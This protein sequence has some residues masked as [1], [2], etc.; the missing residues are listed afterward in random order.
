MPVSIAAP[1][2]MSSRDATTGAPRRPVAR[3]ESASISMSSTIAW[4][5][6]ARTLP[7]SSYRAVPPGSSAAAATAAIPP[8]RP[9]RRAMPASSIASAAQRFVAKNAAALTESGVSAVSAAMRTTAASREIS[10]SSTAIACRRCVVG[11]GAAPAASTV[12]AINA[13][14][15][16]ANNPAHAQPVRIVAGIS[17]VAL[18]IA[19]CKGK[20]APPSPPTAHTAHDQSRQPNE[21][22]QLDCPLRV[23]PSCCG[24]AQSR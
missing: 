4:S 5:G 19:A 8:A 3:R 12:A 1:S 21:G 11:E 6:L 24:L 7:A 15:S 14:S 20:A 2:T 16:S 22:G 13:A 9:A 17:F 23:R 10:A 18:A